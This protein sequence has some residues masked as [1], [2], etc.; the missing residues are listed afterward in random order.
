MPQ[1]EVWLVPLPVSISETALAELEARVVLQP[2]LTL[3][4]SLWKC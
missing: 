4:I 1:R 2:S 3:V